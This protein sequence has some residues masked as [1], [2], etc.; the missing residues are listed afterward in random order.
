MIK[1][2]EQNRLPYKPKEGTDTLRPIKIWPWNQNRLEPVRCHN[3][4]II[5]RKVF[6][7]GG[8][9]VVEEIERLKNT[10]LE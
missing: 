9:V 10:L 3:M 5:F 6:E 4:Q 2:R 7:W 1:P 8:G